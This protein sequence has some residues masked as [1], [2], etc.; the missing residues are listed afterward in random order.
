MN[1]YISKKIS[2]FII[3]ELK[4]KNINKDFIGISGI[5]NKDESFILQQI[6][7]Y[8]INTKKKNIIP[9][10]FN[11][12]RHNDSKT[13]WAFIYETIFTRYG[14]SKK[15]FWYIFRNTILTSKN[16][17]LILCSIFIYLILI[18]YLDKCTIISKDLLAHFKHHGITLI[19][20]SLI[21]KLIKGFISKPQ[22]ALKTIAKYFKN[23]SFEKKITLEY[24]IEKDLE[25]LLT[26][27]IKKNNNLKIVLLIDNIDKSSL[28]S[29][30]QLI[31]TIDNILENTIINKRMSIVCKI[32][33]IR[34]KQE[35][36]NKYKESYPLNS[37]EENIINKIDKLFS[38]C[39]KIPLIDVN[40]QI[41]YINNDNSYS[42]ENITSSEEIK[43]YSLNLIKSIINEIKSDKYID[44]YKIEII[45]NRFIMANTLLLSTENQ[46]ISLEIAKAIYLKSIGSK[47]KINMEQSNFLNMIIPY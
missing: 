35:L 38:I 39:I 17:T 23:L 36:I 12:A 8:F 10:Y 30:I 34:L 3:S 43:Q 40:K 27:W 4:K 21:I 2:L 42:S 41:K 6:L 19:I 18:I 5:E 11:A 14:N 29:Q 22:T 26:F 37:L 24:A 32:D 9:I 47:Y 44:S 1:N 25:K 13:L 20:I 16:I 7:E 28:D 46:Y 33:I 15:R 45:Y 31:E